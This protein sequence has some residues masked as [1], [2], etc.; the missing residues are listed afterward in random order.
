MICEVC[1][2]RPPTGLRPWVVQHVVFKIDSLTDH[3][4]LVA[5]LP[6]GAELVSHGV[7]TCGL[8]R[9]RRIA[10]EGGAPGR[11]YL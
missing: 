1:G 3:E 9:C 5:E 6:S 8:A 10:A 2:E 11:I 7:V 4:R